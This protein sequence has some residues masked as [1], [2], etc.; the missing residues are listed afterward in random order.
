MC[1]YSRI[2]RNSYGFGIGVL[3]AALFSSIPILQG[4]TPRFYGGEFIYLAF[5]SRTGF[6]T[7]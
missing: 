7:N 1:K 6:G 3:L 4:E 2:V 5:N